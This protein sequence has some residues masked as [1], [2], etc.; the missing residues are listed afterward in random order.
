M[1]KILFILLFCPFVLKA[2]MIINASYYTPP[3]VTVSA[4]ENLVVNGDF[5]ANSDWTLGAGWTIGSGVLTQDSWQTDHIH[6]AIEPLSISTAYDV[7]F[8]LTV[9]AGS[10][11]I[12]LGIVAGTERTAS[13][14]YDETITSDGSNA[15]LRLTSV[16]SDWRGTLD[17]LVITVH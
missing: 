12:Q 13:G 8:D 5:S 6:P 15:D 11:R 7:S 16:N 3:I 1:K 14:H 4:P 2:Q 10:F 17:N 9:S